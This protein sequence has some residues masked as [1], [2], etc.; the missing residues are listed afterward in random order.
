MVS[1]KGITSPLHKSH[2][3][4]RPILPFIWKTIYFYKKIEK[5]NFFYIVSKKFEWL[6]SECHEDIVSFVGN[7][8]N[9]SCFDESQKQTMD[10]YWANDGSAPQSRLPDIERTTLLSPPPWRPKKNQ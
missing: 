6:I 4:K 7:S 9:L 3:K 1:F 5:L 2:S 10:D 8:L